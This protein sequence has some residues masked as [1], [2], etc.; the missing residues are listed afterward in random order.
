MSKDDKKTSIKDFCRRTGQLVTLDVSD[1]PPLP[2]PYDKLDLEPRIKPLSDELRE[3]Y[4]SDLDGV[5]AFKYPR[6]ETEEEKQE[7]QVVEV[8]MVQELVLQ[9]IT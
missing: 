2:P 9:E 7:D 1:F 4:E 8:L 5:S 3:K 6:P